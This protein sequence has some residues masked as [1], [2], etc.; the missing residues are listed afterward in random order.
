MSESAS[1]RKGRRE[2]PFHLTHHLKYLAFKTISQRAKGISIISV[3]LVLNGK[4]LPQSSCTLKT[5]A[6][7]LPFSS[8]LKM[9]EKKVAHRCTAATN[10][11]LPYL[12]AT[13][14]QLLTPTAISFLLL[15]SFAFNGP[16]LTLNAID[17]QR[18]PTF[19]PR[20]PSRIWHRQPTFATSS[21]H[22]TAYAKINEY[23]HKCLTNCSDTSVFVRSANS[24]VFPLW[25]ISIVLLDSNCFMWYISFDSGRG[26]TGLATFNVVFLSARA[27]VFR[28]LYHCLSLAVAS[29]VFVRTDAFSTSA[30]TQLRVS[31]NWYKIS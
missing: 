10:I 28:N 1:R 3:S 29:G 13:S 12:L 25:S 19:V 31:W 27:S 16:H 15:P 5:L 18:P 22:L 23:Q 20:E 17:W 11:W 26:W 24:A 14:C 30:Q 7:H 2:Y 4:C 21:Q 6:K 9:L 8:Q